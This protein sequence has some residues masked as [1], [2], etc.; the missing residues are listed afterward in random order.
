MNVLTV[1]RVTGATRTRAIV[2]SVVCPRRRFRPFERAKRPAT[3]ETGATIVAIHNR[4]GPRI[5]YGGSRPRSPSRGTDDRPRDAGVCG[6]RVAVGTRDDRIRAS[7]CERDGVLIADGRPGWIDRDRADTSRSAPPLSYAVQESPMTE[8][9]DVRFDLE[10]AEPQPIPPEQ[11][12]GHER[13]DLDDSVTARCQSD[14]NGR[15]WFVLGDSSGSVRVLE[16]VS[17]ER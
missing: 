10:S 13:I 16:P 5:E 2:G 12:P 4:S 17:V 11:R 6:A 7:G 9:D 8:T 14:R 3:F 15:E 1:V